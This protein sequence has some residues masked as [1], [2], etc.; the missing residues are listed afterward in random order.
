[1]VYSSLDLCSGSQ[2]KSAKKLAGPNWLPH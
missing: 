2:L 1:L